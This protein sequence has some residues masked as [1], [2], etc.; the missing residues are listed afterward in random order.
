MS[1]LALGILIGGL[2][3][4]F[5]FMRVEPKYHGRGM[6]NLPRVWVADILRSALCLWSLLFVAAGRELSAGNF[7]GATALSLLSSPLLPPTLVKP[8]SKD[9]T[10][11]L[12][13]VSKWAQAKWDVG[14]KAIFLGIV[15]AILS[16]LVQW[17]TFL[18]KETDVHQW[19]DEHIALLSP[20]EGHL[21]P[22]L[23]MLLAAA[24]MLVIRA[25]M[26]GASNPVFFV[27]GMVY[28][29]VGLIAFYSLTLRM[30]PA[31]PESWL[32]GFLLACAW[33]IAASYV[34]A[35]IELRALKR[36]G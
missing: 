12:N 24:V 33:S 8:S 7:A 34:L 11:F 3:F 26:L 31:H 15:G 22:P 17:V 25:M 29:S 28:G 23:I 36:S 20:V 14:I 27:T 32:G 2:P 16:W 30:V 10:S 13:F 6:P 5:H 21:R 4:Y 35:R 9:A 18:P 1:Q 19:L